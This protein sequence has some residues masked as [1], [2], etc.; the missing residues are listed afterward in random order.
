MSN[1]LINLETDVWYFGCTD[2]T[3]PRLQVYKSRVGTINGVQ[4]S[5]NLSRLMDEV[6][7]HEDDA[8]LG[9]VTGFEV[10]KVKDLKHPYVFAQPVTD[11][12]LFFGRDSFIR[13]PVTLRRARLIQKW[14]FRNMYTSKSKKERKYVGTWDD[15]RDS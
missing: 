15:D 6:H 3:D 13:L 7:P 8:V 12:G 11:E 5:Y 4:L 10:P 2:D 9:I 14:D 1:P